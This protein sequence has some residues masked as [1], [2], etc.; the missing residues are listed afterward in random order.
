MTETYPD[1]LLL[2]LP[3]IRVPPSVTAVAGCSCGG[4]DW[5]AQTCAIW[6]APLA[7]ALAAIDDAR[8]RLREHTDALNRQLQ[9][10]L[11][12]AEMGRADA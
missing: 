1:E 2:S 7:E 6:A 11:S 3:S 12:R 8:S 4:L 9:G 10:A 5:H